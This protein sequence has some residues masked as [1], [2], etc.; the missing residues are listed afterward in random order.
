M[1]VLTAIQDA[2]IF[3][4]LLSLPFFLYKLHLYISGGFG[5]YCLHVL[6]LSLHCQLAFSDFYSEVS[7]DVK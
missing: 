2:A 4:F 3:W 1:A 5:S 6:F 7:P